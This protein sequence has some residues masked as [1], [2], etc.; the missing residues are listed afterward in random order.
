[1]EGLILDKGNTNS[2]PSTV[3]KD[4][5]LVEFAKVLAGV[6]SLL[7]KHQKGLGIPRPTHT[8]IEFLRAEAKQGA[9]TALVMPVIHCSD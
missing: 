5:A 7:A 8:Q 3:C 9:C 2:L 4:F 6:H 1:M